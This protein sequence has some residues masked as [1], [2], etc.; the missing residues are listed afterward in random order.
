MLGDSLERENAGDELGRPEEE[1]D[2]VSS[3]HCVSA[4]GSWLGSFR[5]LRRFYFAAQEGKR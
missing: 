1:D 4:S 2:R 3:F 5:E